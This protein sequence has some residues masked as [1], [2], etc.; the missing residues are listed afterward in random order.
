[1][2]VTAVEFKDYIVYYKEVYGYYPSMETINTHFGFRN[3]NAS[4]RLTR[5]RDKGMAELNIT[6]KAIK[7]VSLNHSQVGDVTLS[8]N[9]S[10]V[11]WMCVA[12]IA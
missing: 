6:R 1:M 11:N 9:D 8:N 10:G 5:M 4:K 3:R 12:L 7:I 2:T